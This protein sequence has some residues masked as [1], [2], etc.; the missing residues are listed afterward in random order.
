MF[1]SCTLCI[2]QIETCRKVENA[3]KRFDRKENQVKVLPYH[4]A[5]TQESRLANLEEF[6]NSRPDNGS[7]FL[8]CTDR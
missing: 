1:E 4:A 5:M 6:S 2:F 8:V 3:L 7:Q